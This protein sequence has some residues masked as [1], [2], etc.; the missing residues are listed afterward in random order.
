M[1]GTDER[2]LV[3]TAKIAAAAAPLSDDVKLFGPAEPPLAV[4][5]GRYRR[6]FLVQARRNVDVSAFMATWMA[7]FKLPSSIRARVDIEPYS[8]L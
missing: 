6:R 7:R 3:E 4:V 5:R 8:F 1:S 2:L